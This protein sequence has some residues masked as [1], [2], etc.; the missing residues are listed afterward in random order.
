MGKC[1]L[2]G[3]GGKMVKRAS[4]TFTTSTTGTATVNVG[5]QPDV[6]YI[7]GGS[8]T[9]DGETYSYSQA[10]VFPEDNRTNPN[11]VMWETDG[12]T[13]V[14]W[15]RTSTGFYV[16]VSTYDPDWNATLATRKSFTYVAIKYT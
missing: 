3:N 10:I 9:A 15:E 16:T 7:R 5:F 2:H 6:V 11:T 12:L 8:V 4:G 14:I 13:E 1:F